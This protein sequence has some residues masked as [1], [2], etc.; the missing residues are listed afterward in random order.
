MN[1]NTFY[2]LDFSKLLAARANYLAYTVIPSSFFITLD[3]PVLKAV[4]NFVF[5][6]IFL[7]QYITMVWNLTFSICLEAIVTNNSTKFAVGFYT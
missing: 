1:V 6:C 2:H 3:T 5:R 4:P 7:T